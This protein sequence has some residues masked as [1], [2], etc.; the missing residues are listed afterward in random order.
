MQSSPTEDKDAPKG[1]LA[2]ARAA[3]L[4]FAPITQTPERRRA[5]GVMLKAT[6]RA[7]EDAS[8]IFVDES[9]PGPG[10]R[11]RKDAAPHA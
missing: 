9:G 1:E 6:Q 7:L 2:P 3:L 11:L 4:R 10:V 5:I 8:V